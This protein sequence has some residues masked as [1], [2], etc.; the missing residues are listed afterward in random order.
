MGYS[1]NTL[2]LLLLSLD[3]IDKFTMSELYTTTTTLR[4]QL[5]LEKHRKITKNPRKCVLAYLDDKHS[6]TSI[7]LLRLAMLLVGVGLCCLCYSRALG[8]LDDE[9]RYLCNYISQGVKITIMVH[10]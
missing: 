2:F 8:D 7:S 5:G 10:I 3:D 9:Y 6:P 4:H 1:H